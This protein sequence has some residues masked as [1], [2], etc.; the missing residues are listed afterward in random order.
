[1]IIPYLKPDFSNQ[2]EV[3]QAHITAKCIELGYLGSEAAVPNKGKNMND[4]MV[5]T[6]VEGSVAEAPVLA[7]VYNEATGEFETPRVTEEVGTVT[8]EGDT[9]TDV[10]IH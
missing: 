6:P 4:I 2:E 5:D 3:N 8:T 9:A 10:T 1:M 7:L